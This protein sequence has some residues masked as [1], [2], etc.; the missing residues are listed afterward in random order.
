[1]NISLLDSSNVTN[2]RLESPKKQPDSIVVTFPGI[3]NFFKLLI[4][5]NA[6]IFSVCND[7]GSVSSSIELHLQRLY[8][9][10]ECTLFPNSIILRLSQL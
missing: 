6:P 7:W 10:R 3:D 8:F 1:M 2:E 5:C 9:P 4:D